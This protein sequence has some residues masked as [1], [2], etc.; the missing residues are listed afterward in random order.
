MTEE[1]YRMLNPTDT[2]KKYLPAIIEA[3]VIFYGEEDRQRITEK[4]QNMLIIGYSKPEDIKHILIK[5]DKQESEKIIGEFLDKLT[6]NEEEKAKIKNLFLD[7]KDLTYA[8]L[9]PL[10]CYVEYRNDNNVPDYFK[11]RVVDFLK[12][13][14]PNV[15]F[16]NLDELIE[17]GRFNSID[18]IIPLYEEMLDKYL[19]YQDKV[20]LYREY[21]ESCQ[22]LKSTLDKKYVKQ[23][24][25]SI[26]D[27]F[28]EEEWKKIEEQYD[29]TSIHTV[30]S[31]NGKLRN[32][33]SYSLRLTALIEAFSE[34]NEN[35]LLNGSEW[36]KKSIKGDRIEYYKNLGIDLGDDYEAYISNSEVIAVT[37]NKETVGR[38]IKSKEKYYTL[39]MNEFYTSLPEYKQNRER[40][41]QLE[42]LEK[43]DGYDA[44]TYE[45]GNTMVTT[46]FKKVGNTYIVYPI[47]YMYI[48]NYCDYLDARMI[49]EFNHILEL[50]LIYANEN[51]YSA[52]CGWDI[53]EEK[54]TKDENSEVSL[55][56]DRDKRDYEL[57]N[58]I[59]NELISQEISEILSQMG[60]YIFNSKEEKKIKGGTSY[61]R[62]TFIVKDFYHNYKELIIESR[63]TGDMTKL[64]EVIGKDNFEALNKLFH[65]FYEYFGNS[66]LFKLYE[67]LQKGVD[68]EDTRKY[69]E[70]VNK[71]NEILQKMEEHRQGKKR[72]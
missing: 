23:Y 31:S 5:A 45:N 3:F 69:K 10:T 49:H 64:F 60:V 55:N 47:L 29:K 22:T 12:Q 63:K 38:I 16:E 2:I 53:F 18:T 61:E 59:I 51:E 68:N 42:L 9:H 4:F 34:E 72:S 14:E 28:D 67:D 57:F 44:R 65:E 13:I 52:T 71:R 11:K 20:S 25:E 8:E 32:Y 66:I 19:R 27:L 21:T 17:Q 56:D 15:T 39:M 37:P 54:I 48:S 35:L 41:E 1:T 36:Q 40:I 43:D 33:L 24:L 26:R 50:F 30:R 46:N 70:I 7:N 62:T 6:E 58:E